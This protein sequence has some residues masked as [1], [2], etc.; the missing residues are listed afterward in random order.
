M[1]DVEEQVVTGI[2][3]VLSKLSEEDNQKRFKKWNKTVGFSFK[4]FNKTWSTTLTSGLPGE[5]L[6]GEI[7]KSKKY[8]ILL[9]TNSETWLGIISKEVKAMAAF[10]SGKLKL[11]GKMMDLLKLK[12][13]L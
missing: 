12:K 2:H 11:K 3:K 7:D 5:L 6:E 9:I 1:S 8:D 10:Q 4:E 13:V